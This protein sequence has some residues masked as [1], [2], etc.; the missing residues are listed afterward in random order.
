MFILELKHAPLPFS[1]QL[2]RSPSVIQSASSAERKVLRIGLL[3]IP[4][5][6][7]PFVRLFVIERS[8]PNGY[9]NGFE[10]S[11]FHKN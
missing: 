11:Q 1:Q 6:L 9:F 2:H 4:S 7:I 3:D 10:L 5:S 8:E